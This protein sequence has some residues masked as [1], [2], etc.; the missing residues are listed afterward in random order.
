M[1]VRFLRSS[2]Q[3]SLT[4]FF[5]KSKLCLR[6]KGGPL[7]C[8]APQP[9]KVLPNI[10]GTAL[11]STA[12]MEPHWVDWLDPSLQKIKHFF[13]GCLLYIL[14]PIPYR[15]CDCWQT[16]LHWNT[17]PQFNVKPCS[18]Q[19]N[20]PQSARSQLKGLMHQQKTDRLFQMICFYIILSFLTA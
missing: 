16:C 3:P 14:F 10:L 5:H 1:A 15:G 17:I 18:I 13:R 2:C 19:G 20:I 7:C 9:L 8:S 4:C 6:E 11:N 12:S